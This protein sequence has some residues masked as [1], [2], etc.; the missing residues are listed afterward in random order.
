MRQLAMALPPDL[1]FYGFQAKGLDGSEPFESIEET[2]RYYVDEMRK[3]QPHGPYHLAGLC[4]GGLVAVEMARTLEQLGESV[5]ATFLIDSFNPAFGRFLPMHELLFRHVRFY[6]RRATLHAVGMLSLRRGQRLD[7]VRG[8]RKALFKHMR[9]LV[10]V[11]SGFEGNKL[12]GYLENKTEVDLDAAAKRPVGL[13]ILERVARSSHV[14]RAKF[15]PKPYNGSAV[16]FRA[17]EQRVGPY[18]DEFLGWKPVVR[19]NIESFV[20]AGDHM[21]IYDAPGVRTI[22]E[23]INSLSESAAQFE[24]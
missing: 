11:A 13:E 1:P 3:V 5:A 4:Y 19:G 15:V 9:S 20:V 21:S 16:I 6:L 24:E 18:E 7:F 14:A 23:K 12:P 10:T 17:S 22:A 2:A 8:R